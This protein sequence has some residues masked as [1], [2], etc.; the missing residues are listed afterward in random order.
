MIC[1]ICNSMGDSLVEIEAHSYDMDD[2][3]T[4]K[5]TDNKVK[6]FHFLLVQEAEK[7]SYSSHHRSWLQQEHVS[8]GAVFR[9]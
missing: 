6:S 1:G 8:L 3:H 2:I 7:V 4:C 9:S 5:S